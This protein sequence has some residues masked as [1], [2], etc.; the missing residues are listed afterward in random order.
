MKYHMHVQCHYCG[1]SS[2]DLGV[3]LYQLYRV[4]F[5][6][7]IVQQVIESVKDGHFLYEG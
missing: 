2:W 5:T 6:G 1:M 3:M 4:C 7:C